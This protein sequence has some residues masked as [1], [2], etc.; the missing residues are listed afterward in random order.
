MKKVS[1]TRS[2][3]IAV[4]VL[5]ACGVVDAARADALDDITK[6]GKINIGVF[7]DFPPFSSASADMS[8]K[9]YDIDVAQIA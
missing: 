3:L 6:A 5:V 7:S 1:A 8:L 2:S 9:G 4:A